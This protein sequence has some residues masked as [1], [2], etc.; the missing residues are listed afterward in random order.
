M[1]KVNTEKGR[2]DDIGMDETYG[3]RK[4]SEGEESNNKEST[5]RIKDK[6]VQSKCHDSSINQNAS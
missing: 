4:E 5:T 1:A 3:E 2:G 6:S